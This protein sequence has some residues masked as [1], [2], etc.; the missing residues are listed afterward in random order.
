M[1]GWYIGD[2]LPFKSEFV[3]F[4][5][6]EFLEQWGP[7]D[8]VHWQTVNSQSCRSGCD[9]LEAIVVLIESSLPGVLQLAS[10]CHDIRV[11]MQLKLSAGCTYF[12]IQWRTFSEETFISLVNSHEKFTFW[13]R[14]V[15]LMFYF[16]FLFINYFSFLTTISTLESKAQCIHI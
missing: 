16:S 6:T 4:V 10:K 2:T 7:V 13:G 8:L 15:C 3:Q 14:C 9:T 11:G 12:K 5:Q 1:C